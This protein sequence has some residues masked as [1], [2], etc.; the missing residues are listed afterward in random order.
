MKINLVKVFTL[1]RAVVEKIP[2]PVAR[3]VFAAVAD[4]AW[5]LGTGGVRQLET[6][7]SRVRPGLSRRRLR[8]LSRAGMRAYLRYYCEMFQLPRLSR[9]KI[10][11]R[12]RLLGD[13]ALRETFAQGRSVVAVLGHCGNWDLAGA[14]ATRELAHVLTVAEVLEPEELFRDFLDYRTGLGMTIIPLAKDGGV[15]RQ[16]LR[17]T[18]S[19]THVVPLLADRDL[20]STGLEV[21]LFGQRARVA[22]GPAALA[23]GAGVPLHP[24]MIHHERLTGARRRAA[25]SPWGI[26]VE[27][28]PAVHEPGA[29][30]DVDVVTLTQRWVDALAPHI[31]RHPADWHMLQKVFLDDLDPGRLTPVASAVEPD[32]RGAGEATDRGG[33]A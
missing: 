19:G 29:E 18:R 8:R 14:F 24:V 7:L 12:V 4:V 15:F 9:R 11:A 33:E 2:D 28:L 27:F 32:R 6:N 13:A 23:L 5:A 17:A 22:A 10:E 20:S 21:D 30:N 1:A 31:R 26:V 3:A 16:L 25:G